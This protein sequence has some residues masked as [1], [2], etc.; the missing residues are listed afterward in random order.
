MGNTCNNC[1]KNNKEEDG[2]EGIVAR[3]KDIYK[4]KNDL[5]LLL[6]ATPNYY[7]PVVEE[8]SVGNLK[9]TR[10]KLLRS[11]T[12]KK[13]EEKKES[14]RLEP[15]EPPMQ[16]ESEENNGQS[17]RF[18]SQNDELVER[19]CGTGRSNAR[20]NRLQHNKTMNEEFTEKVKEVPGL[21]PEKEELEMV[22]EYL[23]NHFVFGSMAQE[24]L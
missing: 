4:F 22:V 12:Q 21:H 10:N 24:A 1:A 13:K 17:E 23:K 20:R 5:E 3:N 8:G 14:S 15:L 9:K 19:I 18:G 16:N 6:D 7:I 2:Y 11:E